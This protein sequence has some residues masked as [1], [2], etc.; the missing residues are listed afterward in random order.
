MSWLVCAMFLEPEVQFT[1]VVYDC[2][3]E[4]VGAGETCSLHL[5]QF[6]AAFKAR[7]MVS[8]L[9]GKLDLW[10]VGEEKV[11]LQCTLSKDLQRKKELCIKFCC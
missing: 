6:D 11:K 9:Q 2:R 4:T 8:D 10:K 1:V 7:L 5:T 3:W